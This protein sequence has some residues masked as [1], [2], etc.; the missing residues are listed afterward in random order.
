[1][2]LIDA[3]ENVYSQSGEDGI[4]AKI[5]STLPETDRWCVEFGAWDGQYMSNTC[6]LI[7]KD[8]YS[9][10]LIEG[11]SGRCEQLGRRFGANKNV[12]PVNAFVGFTR[13]D[14]LDSILAKTPIPKNFDFLS[15]DIDGN[16]YHVWEAVAD[17]TP[18]VVCI[19]FNPSMATPVEFVQEPNPSTNHG[20]SLL[21]LVLLGRKKGYELVCVTVTNALFVRSEYFPLFEIADN[22]PAALRPDTSAVT[23]VFTGYDGTILFSGCQQMPW[24]GVRLAKRVR[25]LP[26]PFRVYLGETPS[27]RMHLFRVYRRIMR[28]LGRC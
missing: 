26:R 11:D 24:H 14:G 21:S 18:K 19:E 16:D 22:S 27:L 9:A 25:Q 10:V 6:K 15:I 20:S 4:L 8:G 17:Y 3:A 2:K 12:Y 1:M 23:Y 28:T 5:L 13:A 7:E